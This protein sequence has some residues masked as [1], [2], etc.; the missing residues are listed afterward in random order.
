[1]EGDKV[2]LK[3]KVRSLAEKKD[4]ERAAWLAPNVSYVDNRLG[5]YSGVPV[6]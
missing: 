6:S 1:M 2:I 4:A 3:G 5:I